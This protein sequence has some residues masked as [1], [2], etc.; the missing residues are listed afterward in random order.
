MLA[1]GRIWAWTGT[2]DADPRNQLTCAPSSHG[3]H[4]SVE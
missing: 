3:D 2:W 4:N 1:D